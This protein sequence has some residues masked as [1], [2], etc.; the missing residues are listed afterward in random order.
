MFYKVILY[1]DTSFAWL[2]NPRLQTHTTEP[3]QFSTQPKY[4]T[5][6]YYMVPSNNSNFS[7]NFQLLFEI[8]IIQQSH[9]KINYLKRENCQLPCIRLRPA[10]CIDWDGSTK[11]T[12]SKDCGHTSCRALQ[13]FVHVDA[14]AATK[15]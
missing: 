12:F 9:R 7:S 1:M 11:L 2:P 6:S 15:R 3:I 10:R 8:L 4:I 5:K 13:N 14:N